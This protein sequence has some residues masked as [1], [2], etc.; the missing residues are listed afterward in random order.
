MTGVWRLLSVSHK[1]SCRAMSAT[2]LALQQASSAGTSTIAPSLLVLVLQYMAVGY[3]ACSLILV[4][5]SGPSS[6]PV[7]TALSLTRIEH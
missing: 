6:L 1:S 7:V 3:L 4:V 5:E 2:V